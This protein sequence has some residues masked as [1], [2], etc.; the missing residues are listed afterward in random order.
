MLYYLFARLRIEKKKDLFFLAIGFAQ[1]TRL[2][3]H[4]RYCDIIKFQLDIV[5]LA[6]LKN[7]D[8][9]LHNLKCFFSFSR[10]FVLAFSGLFFGFIY[11]VTGFFF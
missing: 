2:L 1:S 11:K 9:R 7:F 4:N 5:I 3:R 10:D 8:N 6:S